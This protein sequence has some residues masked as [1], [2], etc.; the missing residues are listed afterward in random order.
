LQ[1]FEAK[2]YLI[3]LLIPDFH[4]NQ[5][6]KLSAC[7]LL[8]AI[9]IESIKFKNAVTSVLLIWDRWLSIYVFYT[10]FCR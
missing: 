5:A 7:Y 8:E 6:Y 9:R 1:K 3:L 2:H 4:L 10:F